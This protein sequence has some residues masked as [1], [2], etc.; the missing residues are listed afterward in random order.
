[1]SSKERKFWSVN[2]LY[3]EISSGGEICKGDEGSSWPSYEP[4]YIELVPCAVTMDTGE[5]PL[6]GGRV[7]IDF[8]PIVGERIYITVA[9]YTTGCTFGIIYGRVAILGGYKTKEEALDAATNKEYANELQEQYITAN[10]R[11]DF[12][13]EYTEKPSINYHPWVGYFERFESCE[14]YSSII[15]DPAVSVESKSD[16][17]EEST[18]TVE[19]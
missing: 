10:N 17:I 11:E 4:E 8:E 16:F 3:D 18:K 6:K 14:I 15:K 2:F 7:F 19:F 1:M 9:R 13:L 12:T 5:Y